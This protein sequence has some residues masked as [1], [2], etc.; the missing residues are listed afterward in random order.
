[1]KIETTKISLTI[2]VF[3]LILITPNVY[4][5]NSYEMKV[6]ENIFDIAY[7]FD[8]KVI[9]MAIDKET[10]SLLIGT[11]DVN[12]SNFQITLPEDLIRAENNQFAVL[13]NGGEV[14]YT[15]EGSQEL[16]MTFFV[17]AFTE[18]IEIIGT[19]VIPE[20]PLGSLLVLGAVTGI[21]VAYQKSKKFLF[22]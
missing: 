17:P 21:I 15:L 10:I 12:D 11:E 2:I 3:S 4:G 7:D 14:D 13:V 6:D 9:A 20:F 22:R 1:M 19:Y 8:G 18:E 16:T 5:S